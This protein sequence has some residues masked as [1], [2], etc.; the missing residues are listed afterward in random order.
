MNTLALKLVVVVEPLCVDQGDV[1]FTSPGDDLF[2]ATLDLFGQLGEVGAG[3]REGDDVAALARRESSE[4]CM[5]PAIC[6]CCSVA[7]GHDP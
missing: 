2:G 4:S 1:T 3:V 5:A 7:N 6:P